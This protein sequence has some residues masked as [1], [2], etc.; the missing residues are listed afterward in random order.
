MI[1]IVLWSIVSIIGINISGIYLKYWW[2]FNWISLKFKITGKIVIIDNESKK[3]KIIDK[4]I[5]EKK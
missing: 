3:N 5:I 1:T 2:L 4:I